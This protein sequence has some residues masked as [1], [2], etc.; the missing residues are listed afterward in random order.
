MGLGVCTLR[1]GRAAGRSVARRLLATRRYECTTFACVVQ[2]FTEQ[3]DPWQ[4]VAA[5]MIVG[6]VLRS[7]RSAPRLRPRH[8]SMATVGSPT[9]RGAGEDR[10]WAE[11]AR[12]IE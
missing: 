8:T 4:M 5:P 6:E 9:A 3:Q 11:I 2:V 1:C 10:G 7:A 12:V